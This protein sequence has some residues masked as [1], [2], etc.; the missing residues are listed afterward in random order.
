MAYS[1]TLAERTR[2]ALDGVPGVVE[3]KMF[4]GLAFLMDGKMVC[5]VTKD[6]LMLRVGPDGYAAALA[7]PGAGPMMMGARQMKGMV[8]VDA[9]AIDESDLSERVN[10]CVKFVAGLPPKK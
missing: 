5:G 10:A 8:F 7:Q 6:G 9:D 1:E 4:G 2:A 3:K